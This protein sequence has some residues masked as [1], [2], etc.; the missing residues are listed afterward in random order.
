MCACRLTFRNG[1]LLFS[2][3]VWGGLAR[4]TNNGQWALSSHCW[5]L[6]TFDMKSLLENIL[7]D[8]G[9]QQEAL[10][11]RLFGISFGREKNVASYNQRDVF[12]DANKIDHLALCKLQLCKTFIVLVLKFVP[13]V[14]C[15][16][17]PNKRLSAGMKLIWI[18]LP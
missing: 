4:S 16:S 3:R 18:L 6:T 7:A 14:I 13:K 1:N 15:E 2:P 11:Y 10:H 8:A 5:S 17:M 9:C 12:W